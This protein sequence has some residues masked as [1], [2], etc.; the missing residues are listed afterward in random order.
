M[1]ADKRKREPALTGQIASSCDRCKLRKVRCDKQLP[2]CGWCARNGAACAYAE[3][4]KPG[5]RGGLGDEILQRLEALEAAVAAQGARAAPR[6]A[7]PPD[8]TAPD[9][10]PAP[11]VLADLVAAY[12]RH[13]QPWFPVLD[14]RATWPRLFAGDAPAVLYAVAAV[15]SR[16]AP[17]AL[18]DDAAAAL[19]ARAAE[20]VLALT[21][22][23]ATVDT[24]E[25]V[26]VLALDAVGT[27]T[28]SATWAV[29]AAA[30]TLATRLGLDRYAG[31]ASSFA[32][33]IG[34]VIR[35]LPGPEPAWAASG[36][37]VPGP[38]FS[39]GRVHA[40]A[41]DTFAYEL[42]LL[43]VLARV[44]DFLRQPLDVL[45]AAAVARWR[46]DYLV[47]D[48]AIGAWR[49]TLPARAASVDAV[50]AL[51]GDQRA[52]WAKLLSLYYTAHIRLHSLAGYPHQ[53]SAAF[54]PSASAR[55]HCQTAVA[56]IVRLTRALAAERGRACWRG[57]MG[58]HYAWT[59]WVAARAAVVHSFKTDTV[60]PEDI[61]VLV[62]TLAAVG[63]CWPVAARYAEILQDVIGER[64]RMYGNART[65]FADMRWTAADLDSLI[66]R[67][68]GG[69]GPA[70]GPTGGP[71]GEGPVGA[72]R[73]LAGAAPA[74]AAVAA[75]AADACAAAGV[76]AG[77]AAA[78]FGLELDLA[79]LF[80]WFS[81]PRTGYGARAA[82]PGKLAAL[83][84]GG[85]A[86]DGEPA[87]TSPSG[88]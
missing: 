37:T 56:E 73:Q 20:R 41:G 62:Q 7:P 2:V 15:G 39:A 30:C 45:S 38:F 58:P 14:V 63:E 10:L 75:V 11:P 44:H 35:R 50:C 79:D 83:P 13:V 25:A 40:A 33:H 24:L 47:L 1:A 85:V 21:V 70:C 78:D 72:A 8:W 46:R 57:S 52:L 76:D 82:V 88:P 49:Q 34:D 9:G 69:A 4:R 59:L 3:K 55:A 17:A 87:A 68:A 22:R 27:S 48:A 67:E 19:R 26:V 74:V 80:E 64:R 86:P 81:W 5:V 6:A 32:F 29:L 28:G 61:G 60:L 12:F 77:A 54:G 16:L 51:V 42:E 65:I 43:G 53:Q 23:P 31:V 18:A 66:G 71:A 36:D 84:P